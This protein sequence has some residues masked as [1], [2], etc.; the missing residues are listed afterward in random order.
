MVFNGGG[1]GVGD[2]LEREPELVRR[3]VMWRF[4]SKDTARNI[5][6]VVFKDEEAFEIDYEATREMREEL[7]RGR[8]LSKQP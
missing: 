4:V 5:Y 2:P 1:G 7:K 6:G 3:D 8:K